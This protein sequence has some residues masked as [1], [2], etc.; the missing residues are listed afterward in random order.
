M[1]AAGLHLHRGTH[2]AAAA[3]CRTSAPRS[4][5]SCAR[6][7]C[8]ARSRVEDTDWHLDRLYAFARELGASVLVPRHSRY[9]I[10]L[11]RPPENTPMYP[12]ANNTE[13][14]PDALLHRRAALPRRPRRP[15]SAEV[16]RR[17]DAYWRPYHDALAAELARLNAEHGHAV[18][19]DGHSIQAELPWLF[20]G[21]LP[22][23]NLGTAGGASCAPALRDALMAVL[24][25]QSSFSHVIDGRF[26]GG[27]ITR[28]YGRPQRRRA[29]GPARDVLATLHGRDARR[30]ARGAGRSGAPRPLQPVLR[31]AAADD[32]RLAARW[33][34]R[35]RR[36]ALGAARLAARRLA[37]AR[38]AARR[39]RRPLGRG[40]R[41]ASRR[42]REARASSPAP[43]LPGLVDAHSHAFQ[44]AFA[45]LAERRDAA[46][47]DFWSW[48]D[49]MYAR[50]P[51][52]RR[53]SSCAPS[54]RSSTSS[55]CA[56]ATRRSASS[57][58]C[59]ATATAATYADPLAM[60]WALADAAADAGI[61]L[62]LLPVL[63]ERAG[64]A[65]ARCATTSA[66][67]APRRRRRVDAAQR[68]RA[69]ARPLVDAGLAIHSLRAARAA[70]IAALA[71]LADG[72]AGPIHIHVAE[73]TAEVDDCI[74]ATGARPIEWLVRE[75]LLDARWQLVHATHSTRAG[76]RRGRG[77]RRRRRALPE[78][79]GQPRR[80]P[81]AT[82]PAG[83]PPA[84][85]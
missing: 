68:I 72:F 2:A 54:P 39:R 81:R 42:R 26:K 40:R 25:A 49:R 51:A 44:R 78:H 17:R 24:A 45:G 83:S 52:H 67:F 47:D 10:D 61:G 18:L 64:F 85:R 35:R 59:A 4:P 8:R 66:A 82:C 23:L 56:A 53:P 57:T 38:R 15:T 22:D 5:T 31:D 74:A 55:C 70:S 9:V 27:Y 71:T 76:D 33:P 34:L 32:A 3:A 11:N 73:Q 46:S 84:C 21:R 28:H 13:L 77:E 48:R 60:S 58:T 50:R 36:A 79:R 41:P 20:E 62:T 65:A 63:Y 7:S 19:C 43:L 1:S 12:G 16:E 80:R 14:V 37:R 29:R 69:A 75:G 6:A 30:A